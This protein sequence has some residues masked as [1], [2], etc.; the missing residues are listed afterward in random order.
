MLEVGFLTRVLLYSTGTMPMKCLRRAW[1]SRAGSW[2]T[3]TCS[4]PLASP[5]CLRPSLALVCRF[6]ACS[7]SP[8]SSPCSECCPLHP[9]ELSSLLAFSSMSSWPS[10][11][12]SLLNHFFFFFWGTLF[13]RKLY[14]K[15]KAYII[16]SPSFPGVRKQV[17]PPP[18]PPHF[19]FVLNHWCY[20]IYIHQ[21]IRLDELYKVMESFF[22]IRFRIIGRKPKN[23]QTNR[24]GNIDQSAMCY[25]SNYQWI[26][27]DKLYKLIKSFFFPFSESFFELYIYNF[28]FF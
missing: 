4:G 1:R 13:L 5:S 14:L 26:S 22:Q 25:I 28:F 24:V 8:F 23:G 6:G 3:G 27:L 18:P 17:P 20:I 11:P 21:W 10:L 15:N 2:C 19:V 9:G 12:V 16:S 7:S